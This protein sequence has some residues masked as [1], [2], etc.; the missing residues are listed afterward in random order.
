MKKTDERKEYDR[1]R[2][3]GTLARACGTE[4]VNCGS[5]ENIEY[6]HIVPLLLG[7]TNKVWNIVP[8]CHQCHKAAHGARHMSEYVKSS[9]SGRKP[10]IPD[11]EAFQIYDRWLDG[12]FGNRKCQA[13]LHL[14]GG[15]KQN[16]TMQYKRYLTARGIR[17]VRNNYDVS[18]TLS[19]ENVD[20]GYVVGQVDYLDGTKRAIRFKDLGEND[21][22]VYEFCNNYDRG[23][24]TVMTWGEMKS[25]IDRVDKVKQSKRIE[26]FCSASSEYFEIVEPEKKIEPIPT[27]T[28]IRPMHL[29]STEISTEAFLR[30]LKAMWGGAQNP[31]ANKKTRKESA[32]PYVLPKAIHHL[33]KLHPCPDGRVLPELPELVERERQALDYRVHGDDCGV[34]VG[35]L[36]SLGWITSVGHLFADGGLKRPNFLLLIGRMRGGDQRMKLKAKTVA[37]ITIALMALTLTACTKAAE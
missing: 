5:H 1:M 11:E 20:D 24:K 2:F 13:L 31:P 8:L 22:V 18:L 27:R 6:H 35:Y 4:C 12:Q 28:P 30:G 23:R 19:P 29:R 10:K 32:A 17:S 36:P 14:A 33:P 15:T 25:E 7:G 3:D 21:D 16:Q 37:F 9:N 34:Y 26:D